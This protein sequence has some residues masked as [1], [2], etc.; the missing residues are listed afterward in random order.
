MCIVVIDVGTSSMRAIVY[1]HLGNKRLVRQKKYRPVYKSDIC[2]EQNPQEWKDALTSLLKECADGM[3]KN[4]YKIDA[5]SITSQRSSVIPIGKDDQPIGNAIMWQDKRS[6]PLLKEIAKESEQIFQ[7]AGSRPNPV[8]T[9]SKIMWLKRNM[10]KI[11]KNS[12]RM[13]VIPDYLIHEMTGEWVTD[14]TYGSRSLLMNIKT[15]DWDETLLKIF[16]VDRDKLNTIVR[17][18][19]IAGFVRKE[20]ASI[21]GL[22]TGIPVIT[23]GGDQQ[24]GAMGSGSVSLGHVVVSAGTGAYVVTTTDHISDNLNGSINCNVSGIPGKYILEGSI[25]SCASALDWF[26]RLLY[27]M[28]DENRHSVYRQLNQEVKEVFTK[29][30]IPYILPFF[31]GR[32]TPDWNS[33]AKG[34]VLDLTLDTCRGDLV[35]S[36]MESLAYEIDENIK[37][38]ERYGDPVKRVVLSGGMA[39]SEAFNTVLS[40]VC[41]RKIYHYKDSEATAAGAWISA[42]VTMEIYKDHEEAFKQIRKNQECFCNNFSEESARRYKERNIC[43]KE[44]YR[45]VYG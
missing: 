3:E 37:L 43:Y 38:M 18:G 36:L 22:R 25:L 30:H 35:C 28:R 4:D 1:D 21:T 15:L 11:Y 19:S 13:A 12:R 31:Q 17:Q 9:A 33:K 8:Y 34:G 40:N 39:N 7:K 32:G 23:A 10:P 41:E 2:V 16:E 14:A 27:G 5:V 20:F 26:L 29:K 6:I 42:A 45:R 44:I 24:C